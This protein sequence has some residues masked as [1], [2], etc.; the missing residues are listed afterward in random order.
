MAGKSVVM[1][2]SENFEEVV[3]NNTKP[4]LVDF[5]ADWCGPCQML[6]PVI[7]EIA[8][9]L[10]GEAVVCKLNVD[11]SRDIAAE[12][13]V[14]TIPTLMVFKNGENTGTLIGARPKDEIISLLK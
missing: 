5:Y 9:E 14:A 4:V 11:L 1:A 12:Y 10:E 6:S 3:L 7:D 2:D 13:R 8:E